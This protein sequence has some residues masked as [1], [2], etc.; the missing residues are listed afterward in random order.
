MQENKKVI[1]ASYDPMRSIH[2]YLNIEWYWKYILLTEEGKRN[3]N[4][5]EDIDNLLLE[6]EVT[7]GALRNE[8]S[9]EGAGEAGFSLAPGRR[10]TLQ[11]RNRCECI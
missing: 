10:D 1:H 9:S 11:K 3:S 8:E 6:N 7:M 2:T 4:V 5:L